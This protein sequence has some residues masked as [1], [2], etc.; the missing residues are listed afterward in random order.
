M[1]NGLPLIKKFEGCRL[2]AYQDIVGVWTIGYGETKG[3]YKG[4]T[5]TQEQADSM[6]QNRYDE[7]ES[8]VKALLKVPVTDNELGALVS[9]S[10]NIGLGNFKNSTLLRLLNSNINRN[11][12]ALEFAKWNKAGGKVVA[13]L[14]N[15]RAAETTLFLTK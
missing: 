14:S 15:R 12:V 2:S 5:I 10:Y 3:V 7:F 9:L 13:G 6:L 8:G 4:M 1:R 11:T